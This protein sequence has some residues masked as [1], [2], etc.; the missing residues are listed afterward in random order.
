MTHSDSVKGHRET[1][2]IDMGFFDLPSGGIFRFAIELFS[3]MA[4]GGKY[5]I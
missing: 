2:W 5:R 4:Q 1:P 3:G